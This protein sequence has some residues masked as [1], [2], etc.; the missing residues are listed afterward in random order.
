M[1]PLDRQ[2]SLLDPAS[3]QSLP[4][5]CVALQTRMPMRAAVLAALAMLLG[6]AA[7]GA[8]P[9]DYRESSPQRSS[10][11]FLLSMGNRPLEQ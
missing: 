9:S 3:S 6:A 7:V 5:M 2:P 4:S 10:G 1:L 8:A 11:C